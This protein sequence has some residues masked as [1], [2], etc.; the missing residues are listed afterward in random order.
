MAE[1]KSEKQ[2]QQS[3]QLSRTLFDARK[4]FIVG[5]I[6]KDIA[7]K[8]CATLHAMAHI[9]NDPITVILS[10]PGG[11][12]ESGD[13]IHDTIKFITPDVRILATGWAASAGALIFAAANRENRLST[14]NTRFLLHQ[15]SGGVAGDATNIDIQ[16]KQIVI[17]RS[18]LNQIFADAT[19]Q[20]IEK[21]EAD[22][23]R[24]YWMTASEAV[25]YGLVGKIVD[26]EANM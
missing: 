4:V 26:S 25:E 10:S 22:M 20:T 2:E 16:A 8:T 5:E 17:M 19:G 21:I 3:E 24:D 15:P 7:L 18:R 14:P 6:D 11:H 9:S 13:M 1:E 12:V 23:D